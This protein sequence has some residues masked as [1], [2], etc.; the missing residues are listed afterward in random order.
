VTERSFSPPDVVW[1]LGPPCAFTTRFY[2][3]AAA[4]L[5]SLGGGECAVRPPHVKPHDHE[6]PTSRSQTLSSACSDGRRRHRRR[7]RSEHLTPTCVLVCF[8]FCVLGSRAPLVFCVFAF[9]ALWHPLRFVFL[10]FEPSGSVA[11]CVLRFA[12]GHCL[13]N[14]SIKLSLLS[15]LNWTDNS[16]VPANAVFSTAAV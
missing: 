8:A 13:S 11:L 15:T 2:F 16:A 5:D 10:R 6:R 9:W 14:Y 1:V 4:A 12:F 3:F 7:H